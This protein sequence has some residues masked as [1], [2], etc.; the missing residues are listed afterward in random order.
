MQNWQQSGNKMTEI[1]LWAALALV[2]LAG[3][4]LMYA[5]AEQE[6]GFHFVNNRK[7]LWFFTCFFLW[8]GVVLYTI[9]T[10]T[11]PKEKP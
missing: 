7:G 2:H 6:Y 1:Y 8:E 10:L 5:L 11:E 4:W 9:F 3:A